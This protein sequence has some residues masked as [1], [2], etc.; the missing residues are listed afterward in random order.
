MSK[1][2][3]RKVGFGLSLSDEVPHR[4]LDWAVKQVKRI[5]GHAWRG[6]LP[7]IEEMMNKYANWIYS[8]RKI[9]RKKFKKNR[10]AYKNAKTKL[11]YETGEQYFENLELCIRHDNAINGSAPVFERF[12]HFWCNHFAIT[13]GCERAY[14]GRIQR[15]NL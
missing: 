10:H 13:S 9:L 11:R 7:S 6:S 8:D 3:Y 4:P 5:P 1:S 2:F 15:T 12:L 14:R